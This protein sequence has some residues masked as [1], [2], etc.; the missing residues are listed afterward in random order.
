M[1]IS[2]LLLIIFLVFLKTT[3]S[4]SPKDQRK[5]QEINPDSTFFR[6]L[7]SGIKSFRE[8]QFSYETFIPSSSDYK[9]KAIKGSLIGVLPGI[10]IFLFFVIYLA[11]F[12]CVYKK[13]PD[14]HVETSEKIL[15]TLKLI[16]I[17][18]VVCILFFVIL[19]LIMI[20]VN[21]SDTY[22]EINRLDT[23]T[24]S[25]TEVRLEYAQQYNDL[26][27]E[28]EDDLKEDA[29]YCQEHSSAHFN[30]LK[31]SLIFHD[32]LIFFC[33][34]MVI[35]VLIFMITIFRKTTKHDLILVFFFI[36]FLTFAFF[37]FTGID[38]SVAMATDDICKG[39]KK[40]DLG[41]YFVE[42]SRKSQI[43]IPNTNTF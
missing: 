2:V 15:K 14:K 13:R 23:D 17:F 18:A 12:C 32:F 6:G 25:I 3:I 4:T 27:G 11:L 34:A 7:S 22:P 40:N 42:F 20:V 5:L 31:N 19:L 36:L 33:C 43:K 30:T 26:S 21:T 39:I 37:I 35:V 28:S 38:N 10:F 24:H 29:H 41:M 16:S 9:Q 1:R 8:S